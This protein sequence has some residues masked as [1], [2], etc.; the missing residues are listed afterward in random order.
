MTR[1]EALQELSQG[2]VPEEILRQ[3]AAFVAK[4]LGINQEEMDAILSSPGVSYKAY[5]TEEVLY[6]AKDRLW[7]AIKS[8][9][10]ISTARI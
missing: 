3:D 6:H 4:K 10:G 2:S 5:P 8:A 1:E 9:R 7:R